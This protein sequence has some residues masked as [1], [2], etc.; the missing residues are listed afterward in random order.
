M[1]FRRSSRRRKDDLLRTCPACRS[2]LVCPTDWET[3]DDRHWRI[4][5][6]CGEC[7]TAWETIVDDARAARY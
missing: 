6:W 4:E 2:G 7:E 1:L 3:S 5:L